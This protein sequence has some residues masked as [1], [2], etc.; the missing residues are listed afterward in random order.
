MEQFWGASKTFWENRW[1]TLYWMSG[2]ND[3]IMYTVGEYGREGKRELGEGG[4]EHVR[5][6]SNDQ[7]CIIYRV[8]TGWWFGV[9]LVQCFLYGC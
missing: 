7:L 2:E 6:F 3:F 8:F 9:L 5:D 4:R 1:A